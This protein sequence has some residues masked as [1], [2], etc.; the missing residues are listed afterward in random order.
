[1]IEIEN[2]SAK[3]EYIKYKIREES[4]AYCKNKSKLTV[5][6]EK[7]LLESYDTVKYLIK[8]LYE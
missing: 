8:Y 7:E 3:W 2:C 1:M 6:F 5:Q 4:I